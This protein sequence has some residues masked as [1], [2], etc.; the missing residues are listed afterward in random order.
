MPWW[1]HNLRQAPLWL[2]RSCGRKR[3]RIGNVVLSCPCRKRDRNVEAFVSGVDGDS[4]TRNGDRD[5]RIRKSREPGWSMSTHP[6]GSVTADASAKFSGKRKLQHRARCG[7]SSGI[8]NDDEQTEFPHWC[9]NSKRSPGISDRRDLLNCG[10]RPMRRK[11]ITV[12][13]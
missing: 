8:L 3:F 13:W 10:C 4:A 2:T 1:Q 5:R 7:S 9:G 6:S 11:L 12:F